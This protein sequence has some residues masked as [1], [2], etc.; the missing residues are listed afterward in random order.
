M[1]RLPVNRMTQYFAEQSQF[2][3]PEAE[4]V[5]LTGFE[6]VFPD[7]GE[8]SLVRDDMQK[9]IIIKR[10]QFLDRFYLSIFDFETSEVIAVKSPA[11]REELYLNVITLIPGFGFAD[12]SKS[13][14]FL[15]AVGMNPLY[16]EMASVPGVT[17]E[18]IQYTFG[19]EITLDMAGIDNVNPCDL[20]KHQ[21]Y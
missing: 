13:E 7:A 19:K 21:L 8:M 5:D 1:N 16:L 11:T 15:P 14:D 9:G 20:I 10:H 2:K 6:D 17:Y 12:V 4:R 3:K 18:T